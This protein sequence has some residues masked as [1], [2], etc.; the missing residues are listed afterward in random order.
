MKHRKRLLGSISLLLIL[1]LAVMFAA[2]GA[3]DSGEPEPEAEEITQEEETAEEPAA[4]VVKVIDEIDT[5]DMSD[6]PLQIESITLF[7]DGSLRIVPL[8]D[9][10]KN[11]ETNKEVVDGAIYPFEDSGKVKDVFLVRFGNGGFRTIICLMDDGSLSAMSAN[12]LI[13]DHITVIWDNLTG[14]DT[15]VSVEERPNEAG[16]YIGVVGITEDG[17]EIDLDFSLDF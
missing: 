13:N 12:E 16:D 15:Y 10:M 11:A 14:R 17:E 5:E 2:C 6:L 8:D 9:L 7:E 3:K 1:S 4:E